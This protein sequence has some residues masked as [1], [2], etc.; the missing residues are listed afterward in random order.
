[1]KSLVNNNTTY[2]YLYYATRPKW[3]II[4]ANNRSNYFENTTKQNKSFLN[5]SKDFNSFK[6]P[7]NNFLALWSICHGAPVGALL[8]QASEPTK[9]RLPVTKAKRHIAAMS[10]F[11]TKELLCWTSDLSFFNLRGYYFCCLYFTFYNM[12]ERCT[13]KLAEV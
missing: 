1:M 5:T 13:S 3:L 9:G 10:L 4:S 6:N 11:Q 2:N 7:A 12:E 8:R